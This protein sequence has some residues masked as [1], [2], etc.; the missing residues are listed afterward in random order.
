MNEE[1]KGGLILKDI[2]AE[3]WSQDVQFLLIGHGDSS[4]AYSDKVKNLGFINDELT[5][6]IAYHAA[7]IVLHPAPID[8]LPN[9]V[10]ESLSCGT[11]VIAFNVGG[12]PEMVIP[13][14]TGWLVSSIKSNEMIKILKEILDSESLLKLRSTSREFA[15]EKFSSSQIEEEYNNFFYPAWLNHD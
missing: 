6:Q 8:N 15:F 11:P 5:I 13:G 10:A 12:L 9:T 14:K 3:E 7:D 4:H 1:R 2:L